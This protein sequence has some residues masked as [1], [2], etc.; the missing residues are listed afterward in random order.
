MFIVFLKVVLINIT[1]ILMSVKFANPGLLKITVFS[2]KGYDDIIFLSMMS[3][4]KFYHVTQIN[5]NISMRE[6]SIL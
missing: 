5:S 3:P 1:V 2:K 4:T 6:T